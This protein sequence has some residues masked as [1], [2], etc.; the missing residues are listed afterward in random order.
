M[1]RIPLGGNGFTAPIA[2]Y[3]ITG[4]AVTGDASSGAATL[5]VTMDN[6]YTSLISYVT[7]SVAQATA[8]DADFR[9]TISSGTVWP[10]MSDSGLI[11]AIAALVSGQT[12]TRTW[13]PPP[14]ILP[15]GATTP[16]LQIQMLNVDTNVVS[17][18]ALIYVFDIR[19]R[20][21][22]PMGPLLWA[23]GSR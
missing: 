19:S 6:R 1:G 7:F 16:T 23:R 20:E 21:L 2:A 13:E 9:A 22:T 4:H 15:G 11:T 17:M 8:A 5:A 18:S 14:A 12:V 10:T 3:Q